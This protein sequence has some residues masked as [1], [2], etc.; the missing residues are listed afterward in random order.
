MVI[1]FHRPLIVILQELYG[2]RFWLAEVKTGAGNGLQI[3]IRYAFT[4]YRQIPFSIQLQFMVTG[5]AMPGIQIEV[6]MVG[7]VYRAGFIRGGV[8]LDGQR[9][10]IFQ[11]VE[12][13]H[14]QV[15]RIALIAIGR[16]QLIFHFLLCLADDLPATAAKPFRA[17]VEL[18]RSLIG[19]DLPGFAFTAER[20]MG[21]TVGIATDGGAEVSRLMQI[22]RWRGAA[23][24]GFTHAA[25]FHWHAGREPGGA[26]AHK[27]GDHATRIA[28]RGDVP[29]LT[30]R[31]M[32]SG[33]G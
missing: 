19:G 31:R 1:A 11:T 5:V 13:G 24:Q 27:G 21:N 17:A 33:F 9:V 6:G 4:V 15:A 25:I 22:I 26:P 14:Q 18:M 30:I 20:G 28:Q 23:E 16:I 32:G 3:G 10:V 7:Q 12:Q 2:N 29:R 8:I